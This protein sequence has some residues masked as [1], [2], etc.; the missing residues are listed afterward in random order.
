MNLAN[1][2]TKNG[3]S[4][5]NLMMIEKVLITF[6][7][8]FDHIVVA[9]E[10]FKDLDIMKIEDL[11]TS[12]EAHELRLTDRIKERSKGST[13]DQALQA[14]YVKKGKFMKREET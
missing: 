7:P 5:T 9:L 1:Q 13:F 10:E 3:D 11:Q 4:I 6:A 2:M 14:Q 12:F 8:R